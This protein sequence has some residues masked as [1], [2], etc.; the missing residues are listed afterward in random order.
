MPMSNSNANERA[1]R[2]GGVRFRLRTLLFVVA[3]CGVFLGIAGQVWRNQ[4]RLAMLR[5]EVE[6]TVA[7]AM[8][9]RA[10]AVAERARA[11]EVVSQAAS[12]N[13]KQGEAIAR[14]A[15]EEAQARAGNLNQRPEHAKPKASP[16][17]PKTAEPDE[18]G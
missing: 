11:A 13:V 6:A 18:N 5:A 9:A 2:K 15:L 12:L 14:Q 8:R 10:D 16:E 1:N 4:R 3:L 17:G 7:E